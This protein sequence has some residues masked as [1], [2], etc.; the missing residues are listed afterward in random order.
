MACFQHPQ[1]G[2]DFSG[3]FCSLEG[4]TTWDPCGPNSVL[5][6][7]PATLLLI[8]FS[9]NASWGVGDDGYR[10]GSAATDVM[11]DLDRFPDSWLWPI[12]VLEADRWM[13]IYLLL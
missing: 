13:Y 1:T 4:T 2:V 7:V 6:P 12:S 3:T 5:A 10:T 9:A 8:L 11:G